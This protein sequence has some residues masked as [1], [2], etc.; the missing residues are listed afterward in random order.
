MNGC[1]PEA[2]I[3]Q[4]PIRARWLKCSISWLKSIYPTVVS[5][6]SNLG[7]WFNGFKVCSSILQ[8]MITFN[9]LSAGEISACSFLNHN[10]ESRRANG[11]KQRRNMSEKWCSI[12]GRSAHFRDSHNKQH[13][14]LHGNNKT[15]PVKQRLVWFLG[16]VYSLWSTK[17]VYVFCSYGKKR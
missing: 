7:H 16:L 4:F 5:I 10:N 11:D 14:C 15:D 13:G 12:Y 1:C 2:T 17:R 9:K 8:G 3:V 6:L